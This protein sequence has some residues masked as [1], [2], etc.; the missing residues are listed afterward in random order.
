MAILY[1]WEP[2]MAVERET[3]AALRNKRQAG[4]SS[5]KHQD[6]SKGAMGKMGH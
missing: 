5:P 6:Q 3:R 4:K 1:P 2:M